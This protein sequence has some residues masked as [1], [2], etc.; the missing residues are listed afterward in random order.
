MQIY[1]LKNAVVCFVCFITL[2][3]LF[4]NRLN[5]AEPDWIFDWGT[6]NTTVPGITAIPRPGEVAGWE[7]FYD[8]QA[9]NNAIIGLM[10][11]NMNGPYDGSS[12]P[13]TLTDVMNYL[14]SNSYYLDFVFADFES[15]TEDENCNEMVNQ[16]RAHANPEINSAYIGNYGEYPGA[17]DYSELWGN[18][19][20][21]ARHNFYINSG[22]NIAMPSLYPYTAYRN[23]SERPDIFG[24]DLCVSIPHA[25]FW[26]PLERYSTAKNNLPAG[27]VMIP[28]IGGLVDNPGYVAPVPSKIECRSLL[29]HVRLRGADGYY[30]WSNGANT[31]YTDNADFR[32]DMLQ[33]G[34]QPLDWFFNRP[35]VNEILNLTTNKTGGVEWSGI[36]RG[37]R[38]MFIFS[39]Y[40]TSSQQVDLPN[41]IE[42]IPDLSPS[43]AAGEHLLLDYVIGPMSYWKFNNDAVD[44][45]AAVNDAT[46]TGATWTTGKSGSALSFDG[47]DYVT[48]A[49]DDTLDLADEITVSFW[50]YPTAYNSGYA[51]HF[52][53]KR[54]GTS[55]ANFDVYFFGATAGSYYKK[56][57]IYAEAGGV[58]Q[59]VSP[60][61][62]VT[63]LNKWYHIAWTYS[64]TTGGKLYIDGVDQGSAVGSGSLS[65]NSEVLNLG[66]GFTG[67]MDEVKLYNRELDANEIAR[68]I[69]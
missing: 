22:M 28:W 48:V 51:A 66:S 63:T 68:L 46:I 43:I 40:T 34:W 20:R 56:I 39:N 18:F 8:T 15:S 30:T 57:L 62:T 4:N 10:L 44:E 50:I 2:T 47:N 45:M 38:C 64:S 17:T 16:V 54:A 65:I 24:T 27:H 25:L 67:K 14:N 36:R 5:A 61:Y 60:S 31:N 41:N 19:D 9:S 52:A 59:K 42:N 53:E 6:Y 37:N 7:T 3:P 13:D 49:D 69:P 26:T 33:N 11:R 32:D 58:W 23:H 35:G 1:L 29:Q 12:D 55:G 21:T